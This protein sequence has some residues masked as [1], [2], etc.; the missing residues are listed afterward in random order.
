[1][2]KRSII[3]LKAMEIMDQTIRIMAVVFMYTNEFIELMLVET[4][5]VYFIKISY[6]VV[7]WE[8]HSEAPF[9][10]GT[11][12]ASSY[13]YLDPLSELIS[14]RDLWH[15]FSI[16]QIH[17]SYVFFIKMRLSGQEGQPWRIWSLLWFVLSL[18]SRDLCFR[19]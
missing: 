4:W 19:W 5:Y 17:Q 13:I 11:F 18:R 9:W 6:K 8:N 12:F 10:L 15:E 3:F 14:S 16:I 7:P 1:M 2:I